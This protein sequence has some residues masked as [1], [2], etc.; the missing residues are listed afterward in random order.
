MLAVNVHVPVREQLYDAVYNLCNL[1]HQDLDSNLVV[2]PIVAQGVII[3]EVCN[4]GNRNDYWRFCIA[5][6]KYSTS[7]SR[8]VIIVNPKIA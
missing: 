4:N 1:H 2:G 8:L 6:E 7:A 3:H 5:W